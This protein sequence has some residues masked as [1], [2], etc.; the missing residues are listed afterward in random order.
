MTAPCLRL[1]AS[2]VAFSTPHG[3]R[4]L[5]LAGASGTGKSELAL[6]L[7]G[8]GA[9]LVSDDQTEVIRHDNHL[10][11]RAPD[12]I[13]GRIEMRYLGI[14]HVDPVPE[15]IVGALV[16]MDTRALERMPPSRKRDLLGIDVPVLHRIDTAAFAPALKH[17]M[18]QREIDAGLP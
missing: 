5:V 11:A 15:A 6:T 2:T 9:R 16:D 7:M 12:A 8:L 1:H 14:L 4:A 3:W 17:Y 13:R 18:L 10:L